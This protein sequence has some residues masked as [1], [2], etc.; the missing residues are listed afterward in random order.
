MRIFTLF[1]LALI[2]IA[3]CSSKTE[4]PSGIGITYFENGTETLEM[5]QVLILNAAYV[6]E[7]GFE[8][9]KSEP[10]RP[11]AMMYD[12]SSATEVGL[13][14][15]VMDML[16]VGDS[17]Y[18][19]LP[20][21]NLWEV[22]FQRPLPDS[23]S[24]TSVVKVNLKITDQMSITDYQEYMMGL[25]R[26]ANET[27][28]NEEI[29]ALDK[30]MADNSIEATITEE[31]LRY[32]ITKEGNGEK[33]KA[34]DMVNVKYKGMLLDGAEFDAGTYEFEL[35]TGNVIKGWDIGITL[36]NVGS[37]ATFYIPSELAYGSRGA[38]GSIR[39]FSSLIF[40]VELL[41]IK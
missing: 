41:D 20:A 27:Y 23:I 10:L 33:A 11:L 6:T 32:V 8:L 4:T 1:T 38:G 16:K 7:K 13:I 29:A 17:V 35:G 22:S 25:E 12:S 21:K 3:G 37:Q 28:Y 31:G 9:I 34:N 15:E 14:K 24:E 30:F 5:G 18:F 19:E 26:V 36:L 39:P 2:L 40:E